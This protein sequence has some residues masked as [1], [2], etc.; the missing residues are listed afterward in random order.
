MSEEELIN[1]LDRE[2]RDEAGRITNEARR[3]ARTILNDAEKELARIRVM[4]VNELQGR[5]SGKR[6]ALMNKARLKARGSLLTARYEVME[7]LLN[8]AVEDVASSAR[9]PEVFKELFEELKE[10]WTEDS[11][12]VVHVNPSDRGLLEGSEFRVEADEAVSFGVVFKS[13]DGRVVFE[14][15]LHSR[16]QRIRRRALSKVGEILF[17]R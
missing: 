16:L 7:P 10:S 11:A 5:L 12:P 15:T 8:E 17:S 9:Y 4:R 6:T 13:A 3:V 14:N 2:G 1:A